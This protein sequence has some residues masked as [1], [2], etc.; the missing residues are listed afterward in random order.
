MYNMYKNMLYVNTYVG[1]YVY[2]LVLLMFVCM[3]IRFAFSQKWIR[4]L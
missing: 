4:S 1:I 3:Y 2:V